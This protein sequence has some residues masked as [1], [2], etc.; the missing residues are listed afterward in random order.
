MQPSFRDPMQGTKSITGHTS[1]KRWCSHMSCVMPYACNVEHLARKY[2]STV[3]QR[4]FIPLSHSP[5]E[6]TTWLG[7]ESLGQFLCSIKK[8]CA[9]LLLAK[10][11]T[12]IIYKLLQ[13][14]WCLLETS[15]FL[16]SLLTWVFRMRPHTWLLLGM[17]LN[18]TQ[19]DA[20]A[21]METSSL[22]I[23]LEAWDSDT[24]WEG[25]EDDRSELWTFTYIVGVIFLAMT[26]DC[27]LILLKLVCMD[28]FILIF[29]SRCCLKA[30][31]LN[32]KETTNWAFTVLD[33]RE[34]I[35]LVAGSRKEGTYVCFVSYIMGLDTLALIAPKQ[36]CQE[37]WP[38]NKEKLTSLKNY[39]LVSGI[40]LL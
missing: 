30:P 18:H 38:L 21:N 7:L 24:M 3:R 33:V 1:W 10:C 34:E 17:P 9:L 26:M 31:K 8:A 4:G 13:I 40:L 6:L 23:V 19:P 29:P 20:Q 35:S 12:A 37:S 39:Y 5:P 25:Y 22:E 14:F 36:M 32:G 2:E 11:L 15:K 16:K 27:S 28:G